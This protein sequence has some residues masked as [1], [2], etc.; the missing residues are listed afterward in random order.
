MPRS[1]KI[2]VTY[3]GGESFKDVFTAGMKGLN[4]LR[5]PYGKVLM[6]KNTYLDSLKLKVEDIGFKPQEDRF[7]RGVDG[8]D[9]FMGLPV[10]TTIKDD[11]VK[12]NEIYFFT[13]QDYFVK[14]FLLQDATLFMKTEA[15]LIHFHSYMAPGVGIGNT[16]GVVK[17]IIE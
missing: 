2:S 15:D 14:Y 1:R 3:T 7:N 9:T 13:Q 8:E 10:V 6:H 16:R 5:L 4:T 17:V 12:E 11:L